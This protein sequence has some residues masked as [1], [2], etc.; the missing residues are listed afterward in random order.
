[1]S[2]AYK[3]PFYPVCS[4]YMISPYSVVLVPVNA[5]VVFVTLGN[6]ARNAEREPVTVPGEL[7]EP[8]L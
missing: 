3:Q 4:V 7:P 6:F 8:A 5:L 1:M 2:P